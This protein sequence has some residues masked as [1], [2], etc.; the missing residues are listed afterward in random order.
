MGRRGVIGLAIGV[1]VCGTSCGPMRRA[2]ERADAHTTA[3]NA[4]G[5]LPTA[6]AA[7][8]EKW[9][10]RDW[11]Y[12]GLSLTPVPNDAQKVS[13]SPL[14]YESKVWVW[15]R[16][17]TPDDRP[18]AVRRRLALTVTRGDEGDWRLTKYEVAEEM[19]LG[20][21]RQFLCCVV[22][23]YLIPPLVLLWLSSWLETNLIAFRG[24]V[25]VWWVLSVA[26]AGVCGH[27]CF[28]TGGAAVLAAVAYAGAI[29]G[30]A[31]GYESAQDKAAY[32]GTCVLAAIGLAVWYLCLA[33]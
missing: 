11:R 22:L 17:T 23:A 24:F 10:L 19:P 32:A 26:W 1:L 31:A 5:T 6:T 29:R 7:E 13:D 30:L 27:Q 4:L 25:A 9:G 16:G 18:A 21:G 3:V 8:P 12:V 14:A 15:C 28:G 20:F 2:Q 33:W